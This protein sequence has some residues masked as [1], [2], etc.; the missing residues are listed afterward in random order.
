MMGSGSESPGFKS[1]L[2]C[3]VCDPVRVTN[4]FQAFL[5]GE[6]EL[7]IPASWRCNKDKE[8]STE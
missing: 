3:Q 8:N 2:H 6:V 1:W 7:M 4:V 5:T